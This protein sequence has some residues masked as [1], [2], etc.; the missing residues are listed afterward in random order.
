M[1]NFESQGT[2]E[3]A[4]PIKKVF[5]A[6]K[7]A[8]AISGTFDLVK[9]DEVGNR[10]ILESRA[11]L[12]SWGEI[13]TVEF[14]SNANKGTFVRVSSSFKRADGNAAKAGVNRNQ[15]NVNQVISLISE[16]VASL[17]STKLSGRAGGSSKPSNRKEKATEPV[18]P[19]DVASYKA[20][21]L[22][23]QYTIIGVAAAVILVLV[24]AVQGMRPSEPTNS[25]TP[26]GAPTPNYVPKPTPT[27]SKTASK[28]K[29]SRT[30]SAAKCSEAAVA[31]TMVRNVFAEGSAT[32]NQVSQILNE[33]A[34]MWTAEASSASGSKRDWLK[35]MSELA[36]D[37]DSYLRTGSPSNGATKFDQLFANMGLVNN[38][39]G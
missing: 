15:R 12:S 7:T 13:V 24:F 5:L 26:N 25:A 14:S 36:L 35:K 29:P 2:A 37:V 28:P 18:N 21:A 6:A 23:K 8:L 3:Y 27:A 20:P 31:V 22:S 9:I 11:S 4:Y 16:E 10:L 30:S 32:P 38:F 19:F 1:S 34:R 17:S 33:A 39:C